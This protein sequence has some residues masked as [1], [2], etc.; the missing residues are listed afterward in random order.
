MEKMVET[1]EHFF[2]SL[3]MAPLEDRLAYA[4]ARFEHHRRVFVVDITR[5]LFAM[6]KM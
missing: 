6:S 4:A 2:V 1:A 3:G 5:R